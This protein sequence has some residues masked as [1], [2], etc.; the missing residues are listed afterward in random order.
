GV[1]EVVV[2]EDVA[3]RQADEVRALKRLVDARVEAFLQQVAAADPL[4]G[5]VVVAGQV[6]A[7]APGAKLT[8]LALDVVAG[9]V[10][11]ADRGLDDQFTVLGGDLRDDVDGAA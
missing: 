7:G 3:G 9:E 10:V 11:A 6:E 8:A 2:L 4:G 5:V 1:V